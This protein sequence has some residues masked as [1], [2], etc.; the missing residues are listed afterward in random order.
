MGRLT[1]KEAVEKALEEMRNK[2]TELKYDVPLIG[3]AIEIVKEG[4][5]ND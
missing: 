5:L 4:E 3:S 2:P 1:E